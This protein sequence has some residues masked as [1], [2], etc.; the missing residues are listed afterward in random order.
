M[1]NM[2]FDNIYYKALKFDDISFSEALGIYNNAPLEEMIY[3]ADRIR[4]YF[5]PKIKP[6]G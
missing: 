2:N 6:G 3:I 4:Q 5:T 1:A